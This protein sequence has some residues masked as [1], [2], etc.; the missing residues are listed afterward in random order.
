MRDEQLSG[1]QYGIL[2]MPIQTVLNRAPP[3]TTS[4]ICRSFFICFVLYYDFKYYVMIFK[5]FKNMFWFS[6]FIL[7]LKFRILNNIFY[8]WLILNGKK[9]CKFVVQ[10]TWNLQ[11]NPSNIVIRFTWSLHGHHCKIIVNVIW[12]LHRNNT[13]T[14]QRNVTSSLRRNVTSC[15]RRNVSFRFTRKAF[16]VNVTT[17]LRRNL[18]YD[19]RLTT[20]RFSMLIR[21]NTPFTTN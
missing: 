2:K 10:F 20:K 16:L 18:C 21:R 4:I 19:G 13:S 8:F 6:Y 1:C 15:L 9:R 3:P 17:C 12:S 7:Y 5:V 11:R 14:L